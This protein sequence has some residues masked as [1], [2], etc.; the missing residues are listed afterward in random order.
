MQ[1]SLLSLVLLVL[2]LHF[3]SPQLPNLEVRKQRATNVK[4]WTNQIAVC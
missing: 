3:F 4:I 2:L 1:F